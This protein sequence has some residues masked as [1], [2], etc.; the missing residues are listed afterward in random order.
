MVLLSKYSLGKVG[1]NENK[2]VCILNVIL[3][4]IVK[5]KVVDWF[6]FQHW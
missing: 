1:F 2:N 4:V 5:L 3:C 6:Q